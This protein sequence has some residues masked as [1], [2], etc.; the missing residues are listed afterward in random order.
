MSRTI[1]VIDDDDALRASLAEQLRAAGH[2]VIGVA[3]GWAALDYLWQ[4]NAL[5][6]LVQPDLILLDLWMPVLD[7]WQ[8]RQVQQGDPDISNIPVVL[9][10]EPADGRLC[11]A[12]LQACAALVKPINAD[13]LREVVAQT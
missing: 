2:C 4:S 13:L 5:S 7:G 9:L 11:A 8:F 1:L 12:A 10:C 3:H 6:H